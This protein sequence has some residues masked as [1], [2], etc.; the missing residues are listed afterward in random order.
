M[1]R[2]SAEGQKL[3]SLGVI[4]LVRFVP[5]AEPLYSPASLGH[6]ADPHVE[7]GSHGFAGAC[8]AHPESLFLSL[9]R[10]T[11]ENQSAAVLSLV[12]RLN[13][14]GDHRVTHLVFK[15]VLDAVANVMSLGDAHIT[16]H[17]QMEIDESQTS[18]VTCSQVMGFECAI[19]L[20]RYECS[21]SF[22]HIGWRCGVHQTAHT[23][24]Q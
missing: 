24:L 6:A 4:K 7:V 3:T 1:T 2:K 15:C 18:G 17:H 20:L 9:R 5:Q 12:L 19:T 16:R 22:L 14:N 23:P 13:V 21:D 10:R 11:L 8:V